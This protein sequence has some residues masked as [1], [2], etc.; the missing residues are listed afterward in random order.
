MSTGCSDCMAWGDARCWRIANLSVR[1]AECSEIFARGC[2]WSLLLTEP[3]NLFDRC[4]I[5]F[6]ELRQAMFS[7][8]NSHPVIQ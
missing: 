4:H 6:D 1:R 5:L 3:E 8:V 7:A 2:V